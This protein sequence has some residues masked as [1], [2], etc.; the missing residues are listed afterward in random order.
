MAVVFRP[1]KTE[2]PRSNAAHA[3]ARAI[4][5]AL[6]AAMLS[7]ALPVAGPAHAQTVFTYNPRPPAAAQTAGPSEQ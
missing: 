3:L 5:L 2:T 4:G 1:S 6:G 7:F